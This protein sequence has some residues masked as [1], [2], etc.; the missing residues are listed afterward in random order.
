MGVSKKLNGANQK[1]QELSRDPIIPP[2]TNG[3]TR[4]FDESSK[5]NIALYYGFICRGVGPD[6]F[7]SCEDPDGSICVR[8][9][10]NMIP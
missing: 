9:P 2:V 3:S 5:V 1:R 8:T 10:Y 7:S 4:I 6:T